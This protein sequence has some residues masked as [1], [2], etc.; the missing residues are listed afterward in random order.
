MRR[1]LG[2]LDRAVFLAERKRVWEEVYPETA[3]GGDRKSRKIKGQN[4]AAKM[5]TRFSREAAEKLGI[6]ERS[7]RRAVELAGRLAPEARDLVRQTYIAEHQSDL[8]QLSLLEPAEQL[9]A[10]AADPRRGGPAD[11]R[12]GSCGRPCRGGGPCRQVDGSLPAPRQERSDRFLRAIGA[13][14][15]Q[16]SLG[17][18]A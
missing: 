17:E 3:H 10:V 1:E 18:V 13:V 15:E 16:I 2:P 5:A 8:I 7:I 12:R 9:A 6:A 14:R 4:Q 11:A